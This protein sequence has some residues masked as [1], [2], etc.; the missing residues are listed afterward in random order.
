MTRIGRGVDAPPDEPQYVPPMRVRA[1]IDRWGDGTVALAFAA[2]SQVDLWKNA[3]A[4]MHVVGGRGVLSVLLLLITLPLAARR[5][6]PAA[7]LLTAA[8]ALVV[9]AFLV[10][11]SN[12]APVEV[13]LA[14]LI[15]FYS[16]GAHCDDRP[17]PLVGAVAVAAIAAADLAR[18]GTFS[19]SG[20]RPGAWL[21]FAIAWLVGRDQ[22]R[23]RQRVGELEDRAERLE[24][25]REEQAQ[26]AVAE[27]RGRI[28]RELHDVI[29]HN[30][31]VIV[32]QAQAGPHLVGDTKRVVG[33]FQAIE[34]SGRDALGEL[35]RLLGIL[36]SG[37][38]QLAIGPQPGLSSLQSLVEHVRAS[39]VSLELRIEGEPVHLPAGVDLSA[40]RIVQEALTNVVKHAGGAAAE[41]VIRYRERALELDV[42]DDGH[43]RPVDVNGAGHGLIGMRE[44]VALYGGTL[45]AGTRDGGGYAVRARLPF[46]DAT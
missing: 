34:S 12:G 3:P 26:L 6:R 15:A 31:S 17:S 5:Q 39:G 24:R 10:S 33:V 19:A 21:A 27:E 46:G 30:V 42:V 4:T 43:S 37:D 13:F 35:R 11:H 18:P 2:W 20:T 25:E 1:V 14:M 45:E 23:R 16:V 32:V 8:G 7:A 9:A 38:D 40:Y 29:A 22:R 41:V 44:R 28:A 36:R